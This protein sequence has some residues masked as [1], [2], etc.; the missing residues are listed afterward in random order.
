M[1]LQNANTVKRLIF[2]GDLSW[3]IWLGPKNRQIKY[4]QL[5]IHI[6]LISFIENT[7][8]LT[9]I[10]QQPIIIGL[11]QFI[12]PENDNF[13]SI[14]FDLK[15]MKHKT[16]QTIKAMGDYYKDNSIQYYNCDKIVNM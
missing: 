9:Q 3:W 14:C 10:K 7:I 1:N 11:Q 2:G 16:F 6:A 4:Q 5:P 13:I 12:K 8:K 15:K